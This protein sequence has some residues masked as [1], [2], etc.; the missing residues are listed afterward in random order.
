MNKLLRYFWLAIKLLVFVLV[1][2]FALKN[3][4]SVVFHGFLGAVWEA[5]LMVMLGAAF[6]LG[7]VAGLA[8]LLP[9]LYRLRREATRQRQAPQSTAVAGPADDEPHSV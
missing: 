4:Q 2:G 7:V 9:T 3:S 8:A 1:L 6:L 5:P